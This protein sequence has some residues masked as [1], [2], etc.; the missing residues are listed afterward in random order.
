[1]SQRGHAH[2]KMAFTLSSGPYNDPTLKEIKD[3]HQN[4]VQQAYFELI[5][6]FP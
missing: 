1:M 4:I 5:R 6:S 3:L 2:R